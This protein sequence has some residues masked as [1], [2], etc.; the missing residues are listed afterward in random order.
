MIKDI[1]LP[2]YHITGSIKD[3]H[4]YASVKL[5][6][7]NQQRL[8]DVDNEERK[9]GSAS[10]SEKKCFPVFNRSTENSG[11]A[12]REKVVNKKKQVKINP[13]TFKFNKISDHFKPKPR[14]PNDSKDEDKRRPGS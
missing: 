9:E 1:Y 10:H 6:E 14:R 3:F 5:H 11:I 12:E 7:R 8:T 2:A 13:P 4:L